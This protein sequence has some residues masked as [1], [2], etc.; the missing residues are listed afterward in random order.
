MVTGPVRPTGNRN[1]RPLKPDK[2]KPAEPR[3][4]TPAY[5]ELT[6]DEYTRIFDALIRDGLVGMEE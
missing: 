1:R 5:Q 6:P 4:I 3:W 2:P